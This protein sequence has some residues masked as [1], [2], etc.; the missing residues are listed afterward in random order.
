LT[1]VRYYER[2]DERILALYGYTSTRQRE[3]HVT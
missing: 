1:D 3:H 2:D